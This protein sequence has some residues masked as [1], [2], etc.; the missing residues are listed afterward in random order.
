MSPPTALGG[1]APQPGEALRTSAVMVN[2]G[3]LEARVENREARVTSKA[4][5]HSTPA[6]LVEAQVW[7]INNKGELVLTATAPTVIPN[8]P[9][10]NAAT[11]HARQNPS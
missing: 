11:C 2:G 9:W 6:Q 7:V 10:M 5:T 1:L 4:P 8:N 3:T